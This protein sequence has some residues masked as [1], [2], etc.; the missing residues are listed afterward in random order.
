MFAASDRFQRAIR[1]SG[2]RKSVVDIHGAFDPEVLYSQ[3]PLVDGNIIVDR[4]AESRRSGELVIA[5]PSVVEF[6]LTSEIGPYDIEL[7]VYSGVVYRPDDEELVPMGVFNVEEFSWDESDGFPVVTLQVYDRS[8]WIHRAPMPT[9]RNHSGKQVQ[10]VIQDV[11][12]EVFVA[13]SI[14]PT[15]DPELENPRLPGG[16]VFDSSRWEVVRTCVEAMGAEGYFNV[17]GDFVV[18]P[19]PDPTGAV[20]EDSV[21]EFNVGEGF[22]EVQGEQGEEFLLSRPDGVLISATRGS[23]RAETY[24]AVA[25][26]G[27]AKDSTSGQPYALAYDNDPESPTYYNGPFGRSVLRIDNQALVDTGQCSEVAAATLRNSLGT[28]RSVDFAAIGNPALEGGDFIVFTWFDGSQE[29]H[30][31]DQFEY[32]LGDGDFSSSTRTSPSRGSNSITISAGTHARLRLPSAPVRVFGDNIT[33][34]TMR[35]WWESS[36]P[37]S[38]PIA[39]YDLEYTN[40]TTKETEIVEVPAYPEGGIV[41]SNYQ[42]LSLFAGYYYN[43]RVRAVDE[44]GNEGRFSPYTK[45]KTLGVPTT[46]PQIEY[47][48]V[49][50]RFNAQWS[51]TYTSAGARATWK[52]ND[53]YQGVVS[54]GNGN[55]RSL[56]GF[57][58]GYVRGQLTGV[59]VTNAYVWLYFKHWYRNSGGTAIIGTHDYGA[60]PG[61]WASSH[62]SSNRVRS[63]GW[64]KP[65][66]RQIALG[67]TVARMF[68]NGN[69]KGIAL[70]PA[71]SSS[72][73]YYG[74]AKG[75]GSGS[76]SPRLIIIGRKPV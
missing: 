46:G 30:L 9:P 50:L 76:L 67:S 53:C 15:F 42:L 48:T 39:R 27:A 45:L 55:E 18:E 13:G 7:F 52:G 69:A 19:I 21:W 33:T 70:G 72:S 6:F 36:S 14:I 63:S 5:D 34:S 44:G 10:A 51:G 64:P 35:L 74:V 65:G 8:R 56:I 68:K 71:P 49:T 62:V 43:I 75:A 59:T 40:L 26:L 66:S 23:S 20:L 28:S 11:L 3:V 73:I 1:T 54:G 37:G 22:T 41:G 57:D 61:T 38:L 2:Q 24:N 31:L 60:R 12:D 4:N 58:D 16:S 47:R 32:P 29:V 17:H 25:V